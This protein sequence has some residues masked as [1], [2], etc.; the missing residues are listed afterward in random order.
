MRKTIIKALITLITLLVLAL[1]GKA[2]GD[3][4]HPGSLF[5]INVITYL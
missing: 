3:T 2:N 5:Y 1:A 4:S